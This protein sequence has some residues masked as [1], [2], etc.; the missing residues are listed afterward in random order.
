MPVQRQ[1]AFQAVMD[2]I[3]S[4][5]KH[6]IQYAVFYNIAG[7]QSLLSWGAVKIRDVTPLPED[8]LAGVFRHETM[9]R[10]RE[11]VGDT[12][13]LLVAYVPT[14]APAASNLASGE[15]YPE[16]DASLLGILSVAIGAG[17]LRAQSTRL[18]R[19]ILLHALIILAIGTVV[20]LVI[21]ALLSHPIAALSKRVRAERSEV[22]DVP[23]SLIAVQELV[24]SAT[25]S[26]P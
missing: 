8:V 11:P 26:T 3:A 5:S 12:Q 17:E 13:H 20:A 2:R 16:G 15:L 9:I 23:Q 4:T 7:G 18:L 10:D 6:R 25:P 14:H 21:A 19:E 24:T 22:E 1:I